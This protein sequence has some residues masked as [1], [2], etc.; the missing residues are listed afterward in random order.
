MYFNKKNKRSGRLWQGR[1]L[2]YYIFD[3]H[4]LFTLLATL[5]N[6]KLEIIECAEHSRIRQDLEGE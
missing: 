6:P 2:S 1:Y 3:E 5:L 4:Y